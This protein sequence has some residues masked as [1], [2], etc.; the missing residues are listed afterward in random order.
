[1]SIEINVCEPDK[2][3]DALD[4]IAAAI[5]TKLEAN[6][7]PVVPKMSGGKPIC[8]VGD[9]DQR[10]PNNSPDV[11]F[12]TCSTACCSG[13]AAAT[14]PTKDAGGVKA[15]CA[16]ETPDACYCALPSTAGICM[17]GSVFGVWRKGGADGPSDKVTNVKC[18]GQ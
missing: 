11:A 15:A 13:W 18:A 6:C 1:D 3:P 7:L 14:Q 16:G 12:P 17:G 10:T 9:V 8:I 4:S 5:K 2:Y